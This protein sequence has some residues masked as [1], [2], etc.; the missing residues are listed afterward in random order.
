MTTDT[1]NAAL[2]AP[3]WEIP[4]LSQQAWEEMLMGY[5]QQSEA[6]DQSEWLTH[7]QKLRLATLP[8]WRHIARLTDDDW[9]FRYEQL[10]EALAKKQRKSGG[11]QNGVFYTSPKVARYLTE[12]TLGKSLDQA[13]DRLLSALRDNQ[14]VLAQ[15][16]WLA[17]Q[18]IQVVDPACGTGVFLMEALKLFHAFYQKIAMTCPEFSVPNAAHVIIAQHL[19]G[20]DLDPMSVFITECRLVQW[21]AKLDGKT[22]PIQPDQW[23]FY[24]GDTLRNQWL[25]NRGQQAKQPGFQDSKRQKQWHFILGNPPYIT[26]VRGQ[27]QRFRSLQGSGVGYYQA[28]MDL[29]DAFLAWAIDH[30]EPGGQ[31]A[32]VLPAYWT[33]RSNTESLR[34]RLWQ[35]GYFRE[36]WDFGSGNLFKNAPGHHTALLIW[37]KDAAFKCKNNALAKPSPETEMVQ[38]Q[39]GLPLPEA[40]RHFLFG[41]GKIDADLSVAQLEKQWV[42]LQSQSGKLLMGDAVELGLLNRLAALPPLLFPEQIQQGLVIPQ[43]RLKP[44]DRL[45]LPEVVRHGLGDEPGV[46]VLNLDEQAVL[47]FNEAE[48]ALLRPYY[49][50][51]EFVAFQGFAA[52]DAQEHLLYTDLQNR[53]M[54]ESKPE[55]FA[56]I[57]AHLDRFAS[58]NT[59]AFAPYGLHRARQA[60]WFEDSQKILMPRQVLMPMAAVVP[61]PA[62]VNEGFLIL[63]ALNQ[64]PHWICALLNSELAW[65]WFYH[66]KRKGHRLQIDKEVLRY[67]PQPLAIPELI[68]AE[69]VRLAQSLRAA[70]RSSLDRESAL[71]RLNGL[72]AEVYQLSPKE[73]AILQTFRQKILPPSV[74]D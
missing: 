55:L 47:Q 74:Q 60:I 19:A 15:E 45:R 69:C 59:S 49:R 72:M 38:D 67:F 10:Q 57:R 62:Y 53:R 2:L 30:L 64:N 26:E 44:M 34:K 41:Q 61:F 33:Q 16:Q 18:A 70:E 43:G 4:L 42:S 48:R 63:R 3:G 32:Y 21:A 12:R 66:Q 13:A 68:Q 35:E 52:A 20:M 24:V 46:F 71:Q 5:H 25:D 37:Q 17:V 54:V 23:S 22:L 58:V 6:D 50:P 14:P 56:R 31:L 8:G 73:V 29:C 36:A 65:F 11:L 51:T 39:S 1:D 7:W 28:K 9:V 27:S 40:P